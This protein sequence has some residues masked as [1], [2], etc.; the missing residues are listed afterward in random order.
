MNEL[1]RFSSHLFGLDRTISCAN[2][3]TLPFSE[4]EMPS[5][6]GLCSITCEFVEDSNQ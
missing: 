1:R 6:N 4:E 3:Y 5:V 2:G